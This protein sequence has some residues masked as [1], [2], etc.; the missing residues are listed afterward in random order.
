MV[1]L[2][3]KKRILVMLS[4]FPSVSERYLLSGIIEVREFS[5]GVSVCREIITFFL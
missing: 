3:L 2:G 4:P 1:V 5:K